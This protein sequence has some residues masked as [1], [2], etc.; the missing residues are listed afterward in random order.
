MTFSR[1]PGVLKTRVGYT[2][3]SAPSPTYGTV[4]SGDGHTE[5]MRVWFDT[6]Q[7]SYTQLLEVFFREHSPTGRSKAQYKS[8]IWYHGEG[9]RQAA[10]AMVAGLKA[11]YK[12]SVSTTLDPVQRWYDAEDYHQQYIAKQGLRRG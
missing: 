5:A 8:A 4:C 3:G 11:K 2:G 1:L 6:R 9:Q 12:V 10:E 7:I